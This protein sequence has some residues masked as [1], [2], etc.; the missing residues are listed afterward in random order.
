MY[1]FINMFFRDQY[2]AIVY[3]ESVIRQLKLRNKETKIN[4]YFSTSSVI[5]LELQK[6]E[7]NWFV[8]LKTT[9]K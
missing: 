8:I 9:Q 6:Q 2:L 5:N 1:G 4:F 7:T 3:D